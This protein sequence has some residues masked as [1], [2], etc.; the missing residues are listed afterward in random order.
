MSREPIG[1][2]LMAY[3]APEHLDEVESFLLD[4]R[5][6]RETPRALVEEV[7]DRYRAIGGGSPLLGVTTAQ[8]SALQALLTRR[9]GRRFRVALGMRHWHPTIDE[10]VVELAGEGCRTL[11]AIPLAPQFS[12]LSVGAYLR[13][14]DG[15]LAEPDA[16]PIG[17]IRRIPGFHRHPLFFDAWADRLR[18]AL[19]RFEARE[20]DP[21]EVELLFTAHSLPESILEEGDPYPDQFR[22]TAEGVMARLAELTGIGGAD[23][24]GPAGWRLCYQ[25]AGARSVPWL[26]PSI[27]EVLD[28]LAAAGRR[29][30][31]AVPV[32][33]VSDH[34]EVLYDLDVEAAVHAERLGVHFDR[35][36]SLNT[37][38]RFI[39]A[40]A[41][42]VLD[43]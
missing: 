7:K 36:E 42:L 43:S 21:T 9:A 29:H 27:G 37:S 26:G 23:G 3:G 33:F 39:E 41:E 12:E 22:E 13:A 10:G 17:E 2:L 14:L 1:V 28:E 4:V 18:S 32:G 40:L 11:V 8:A 20:V 35:T 31:L 15:A 5:G 34:V 6:G 16:E 19:A 30:V 24:R 38:P 25:S